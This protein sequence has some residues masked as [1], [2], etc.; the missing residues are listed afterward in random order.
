MFA[1]IGFLWKPGLLQFVPPDIA[2]E[3]WTGSAP[4]DYTMG[5]IGSV[6]MQMV[7]FAPGDVNGRQTNGPQDHLSPCWYLV[8]RFCPD[9]LGRLLAS[10]KRK[11]RHADIRAVNGFHELTL[12]FRQVRTMPVLKRFLGALLFYNMG[13]KR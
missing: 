9:L 6:L 3:I 1:G 7:G 12:V 11:D 10:R 4:A 8:G 5:Y 2:A 13:Y